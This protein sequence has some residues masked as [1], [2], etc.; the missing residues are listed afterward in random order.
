M[1][2]STLVKD[3]TVLAILGWLQPQPHNTPT[4]LVLKPSPLLPTT[5]LQSPLLFL[6]FWI[7]PSRPFPFLSCCYHCCETSS[8][9]RRSLIETCERHDL[10]PFFLV[11]T[12]V[13]KLQAQEGRASLRL[14]EERGKECLATPIKWGRSIISPFF[15]SLFFFSFPFS[16]L[17]SLYLLVLLLFFVALLLIFISFFCVCFYCCHVAPRPPWQNSMVWTT[18]FHIET[19]KMHYLL[20]LI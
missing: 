12:I 11:A 9:R 10:S 16:L 2:T 13:V 3:E 20:G 4:W 8:S 7:L 1:W 5:L 15:S 14:V 18:K 19:C 17:P 6:S